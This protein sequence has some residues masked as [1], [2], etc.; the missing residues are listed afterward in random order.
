V[1]G[2]GGRLI[3]SGLK[4]RRNTKKWNKREKILRK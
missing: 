4:G 3:E 1:D 2:K